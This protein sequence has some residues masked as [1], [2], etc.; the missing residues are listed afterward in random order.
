MQTDKHVVRQKKEIR[1]IGIQTSALAALCT[2]N[3]LGTQQ[4]L[5]HEKTCVIPI[6]KHIPICITIKPNS[7]GRKLTVVKCLFL[8]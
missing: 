2:N 8:A 7:T 1:Q 4:M 6:S 5:M 3:F